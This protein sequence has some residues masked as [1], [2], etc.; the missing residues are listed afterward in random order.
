MF[1]YPRINKQTRLGRRE[2]EMHREG[3]GVDMKTKRVKWGGGEEVRY[4]RIDPFDVWSRRP[5][6][7]VKS[8]RK[9][10]R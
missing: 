2:D 5:F 7:A 6:Y 1:I 3:S 9:L 8:E 10:L 4:H